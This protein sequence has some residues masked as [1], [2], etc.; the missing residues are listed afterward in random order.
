MIDEFRRARRRKVADT[1][2]RR[3]HDDRQRRRPPRQPVRDRHAADGQRAAGRRRAVPVPLQPQRRARAARRRSKSAR[4]CC[5][6]T[7][8]QRP[9]Q[10]G[11][12]FRF[13][14]VPRRT[15]A[16]AARLDRRAGR[17]VRVTRRQRRLCG[18]AAAPN[19]ARPQRR[20]MSARPCVAMKST[21]AALYAD[22]LDDAEAARGRG[23]AARRLRRAGRAQR[24]PALPGL[25][26]PRLSRTRS[27][28]SSRP[29]LPLT[30]MPDSWLV[31]TPGERPKLIY[32]QPFD[33]WHV[34]PQRAVG[35]L[36]RA[37]RHRRSSA[38]RTKRCSTCR[39]TPRAARS[40]ASRRA[41]W[42]SSCRTIRRRSSTT[43]N[44][45]ARSRRRT[46]SR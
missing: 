41:R 42:A 15:D 28:R 40:S 12:G 22:H 46:R 45:T 26:R 4:T 17:P 33:Y 29:G 27:I 11:A 16:A 21:C 35:R 43:W 2:H 1:V 7:Q 39:R 10:A 44:T 23:A 36:G 34:V 31:Y 32:L 18:A 25:R 8:R 30:R 5:G 20:A 37:L 13:I 38:R 6:R 14:T 19:A 24:A 9:G 3:R